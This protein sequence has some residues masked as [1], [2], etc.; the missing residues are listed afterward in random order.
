MS[1]TP[2][3]VKPQK[4]WQAT[5]RQRVTS[6]VVYLSSVF[7]TVAIVALTPLA[8]KLAY[9]FLFFAVLIVV[10]FIVHYIRLGSAAAK[11][12]IVRT[13]VAAG[14]T[15]ALLPIISILL[16]VFN[17][18]RRGIHWGLFTH[19]MKINS[20]NDPITQG[21]LLHA[22]TGTAIVV[23]IALIISLPIGLLTAVYL[24]EI[25]GRFTRP[26]KFLVQA[27]SG[28]PSIVA[29]LF[30]LSAVV[31]PLTKSLNGFV[32][33]LSLVILMIPTIART[34]E[35]VL[36]LIPGDLREAGVALGGT[37]WRTVAMVV[38]PAARSGLMTAVI[39]GIAR[40][41]GETAPII[42]LTGGGDAVNLNPFS[43]PMGSLPFYIWKSFAVGTE[44][45]ITRAWAAI[46]VLLVI[47][48]FLFIT[49]RVLGERKRK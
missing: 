21:G 12:S 49:A 37:Q 36:L 9:F 48:F 28:V 33:S 30:I 23:L 11:D 39:L 15:V 31:Y 13:L 19:D 26:I 10:D 42:L 25:K 22:L 27:M 46:L 7:L 14:I 32:G 4:P 43:G 38:V 24:T 17:R 5:P 1:T 16:T 29:G 35:E 47:V 41:A 40:V 34:A 2:L 6:A 44:E 20:V 45:S 3:A 18:G 8:G